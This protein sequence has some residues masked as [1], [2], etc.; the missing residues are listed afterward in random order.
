MRI[1]LIMRMILRIRLMEQ[2]FKW[3]RK[4]KFKN[5]KT[6]LVFAKLKQI[7]IKTSIFYLFNLEFYI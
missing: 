6:W 1:I 5:L 7:F 3:I 2:S 4:Q